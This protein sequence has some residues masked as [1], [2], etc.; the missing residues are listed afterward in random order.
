MMTGRNFALG[1]GLMALIG[2][3]F[4]A[5]IAT[6]QPVSAQT[7]RSISDSE[8]AEIEAIVRDY[9]LENPEIIPEAINNLQRREVARMIDSNRDEIQTPF[10]GAW[11]GNPDGDVI[12]VEFFDYNCPYCRKGND[13]VQRLLKEDENLKVVWR[14]FP[15]LGPE[16][17]RAAMA[18]LSAAKQ[19][20]YRRFHD[21]MFS[22][23]RRLDQDKLFEVIRGAGLNEVT[24]AGDLK[25]DALDKEIDANLSLG[26]AL[27]IGGTPAYVIGD[28]ILEGAVGYHAMKEAIDAAR[29]G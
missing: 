2:F 1:L 12:L 19:G 18:S 28:R 15:V 22:D 8:R 10:E 20:K 13:D 9:I 21:R 3:A 26:R 16:S 11:A 5:L 7:A 4:A 29:K 24:T 17:R 6:R 25:R 14:D 27:G 23:P